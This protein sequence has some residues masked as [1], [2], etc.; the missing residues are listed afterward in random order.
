MHVGKAPR[1]VDAELDGFDQR[2]VGLLQDVRQELAVDP[3]HDE[4]HAVGV[5]DDE[6]DEARDVFT[7]DA[8][9]IHGLAAEA[10]DVIDDGPTAGTQQGLDGHALAGLLVD[11]TPHGSESAGPQTPLDYVV[12]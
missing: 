7:L 5:V 4:Q 3:L 12:L 9:Q 6:V 8:A 2:Q 1:E 10:S 11:R